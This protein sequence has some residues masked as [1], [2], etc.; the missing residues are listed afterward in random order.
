MP[1]LCEFAI[2]PDVFQLDSYDSPDVAELYLRPLKDKL[3]TDSIVR[4]LRSGKWCGCFDRDD[5]NFHKRTKEIIKKL[6]Q[7]NRIIDYPEQLR[8]FDG[9]NEAWCREALESHTLLPLDGIICSKKTYPL[10]ESNEI[11]SPIDLLHKTQWWTDNR[12]DVVLSRTIDD[13]Q[14]NLRLLLSH[15]NSLMFIDRFLDPS[16]PGFR[17][18]PE[19][20]KKMA[21]RNPLPK[22]EIH[23]VAYIGRGKEK[24]PEKREL[25]EGTFRNKLGF[26]AEKAG[27]QI[28]VFIWDD[29]HDRFLITDI[30]G[31]FLGNSFNTST[32][33]RVNVTW[34]KLSRETRD[35]IQF[36]FDPASK[37]MNCITVF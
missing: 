5:R 4:N 13:Y 11:I 14:T 16:Q 24:E 36:E 26:L 18:F 34:S 32:D 37:S 22:V 28:E 12:S 19:L 9:T 2:T 21:A 31:I 23:R 6:K 3:L 27:M 20:L 8:E 30:I 33:P 7:Q 15:A 29:F 10:F 25:W 17:D 35:A 1:L